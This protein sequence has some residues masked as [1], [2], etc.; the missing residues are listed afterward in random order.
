FDIPDYLKLLKSEEPE[1]DRE[2]LK[3]QLVG[4]ARA[5]IALEA[6]RYRVAPSELIAYDVTAFST[7]IANR[8][9]VDYSLTY[10]LEAM[11]PDSNIEL[12]ER[13]GFAHGSAFFHPS[14]GKITSHYIQ[15]VAIKYR[16]GQL[17]RSFPDYDETFSLPRPLPWD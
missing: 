16:S 7:E 9:A 6:E 1:F 14:D 17:R 2:V 3:N 12:G 5:R 4:E 15:A 13:R 8:I 10:K 11:S